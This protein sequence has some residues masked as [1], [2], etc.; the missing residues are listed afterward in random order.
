MYLCFICVHNTYV[1]VYTG[2]SVKLTVTKRH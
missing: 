1:Y 2:I